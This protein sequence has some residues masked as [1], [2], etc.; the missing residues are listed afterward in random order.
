MR[1]VQVGESDVAVQ[2]AVGELT[3]DAYRVLMPEIDHDGYAEEL[4]DVDR[5]VAQAVVFAALD[6]DGTVL[7]GVTYVPGS[8]SPLAEWKEHAAGIRMLAV[9]DAARGRGVG[10]ALVRVCLD[11]AVDAGHRQVLLHS[12]WNMEAAHRLYLR[13]GFVRDERI[14][15]FL[16][17]YHLMGFRLSL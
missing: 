6:D 15:V 10:E 17:G 4:R 16:D 9:I 12:T 11:R 1:I 5:R 2:R 8:A 13:L 7:G 14:D 3:V